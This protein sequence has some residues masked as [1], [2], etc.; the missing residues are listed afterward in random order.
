MSSQDQ[1]PGERYSHQL[2]GILSNWGELII[3]THDNPDPDAIAAGWGIQLLLSE[4]LG[5]SSRLIGGGAIVRAENRRLVELLRPPIELIDGI[6]ASQNAA[7][8]LVDCG[9]T[10]TNHLLF[11]GGL[12]PVAVIDHH[13]S[14]HPCGPPPKFSDVRPD[15]A[16]SVTIV[17]SYLREQQVEPGGNLATAMV[18]AI[19]S[20]TKGSQTRHSALDKSVLTWLTERADPTLVAQIENAPLPRSYFGDLALAMQSTFVYDTAA[21]CL[22]PRAH[23]AEIVGEVADLLIRDDAIQRVLCGAAFGSDILFSVRTDYGCGDAAELVRTALEGLGR[24]GGHKHRA[25]GKAAGAALRGR[26]TDEM[27]DD[28]RQRW[29]SACEVRRVPGMRLVPKSQIDDGL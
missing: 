28:L 19:R 13:P 9:M 21:F 1:A 29:L 10:A 2:L 20:E 5:K 22:L 6:R 25:G 26:I 8:I 12:E 7:A 27:H 14:P 23:S 15:V 18:Y 16:A 24:G 17:A 4:K 3:V 11:E